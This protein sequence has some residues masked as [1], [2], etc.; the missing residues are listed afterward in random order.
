MFDW[1]WS[2]F[3][4]FKYLGLLAKAKGLSKAYGRWVRK[5]YGPAAIL[6]LLETL[7]LSDLRQGSCAGAHDSKHTK[8]THG[9]TA[10]SLPKEV[11]LCPTKNATQLTN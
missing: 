8:D 10:E 9:C 5:G 3:D 4:R 2:R 11:E 7:R 6:G 1:W